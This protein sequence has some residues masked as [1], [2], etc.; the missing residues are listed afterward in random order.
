MGSGNAETSAP[1]ANSLPAAEGRKAP[2]DA[3][4]TDAT[5]AQAGQSQAAIQRK[6]IKNADLSLQASDP[7]EGARRITAAAETLGGFVVTS[8]S[9]QSGAARTVKVT[10]R[11]PAEKFD[12]FLAQARNTGARVLSK[13]R[14]A[15]M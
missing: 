15:R 4:T 11:V 10:A 3:K 2:Y 12:E 1:N 14:P 9:S 6:V 8:E 7:D 13:N 5:L